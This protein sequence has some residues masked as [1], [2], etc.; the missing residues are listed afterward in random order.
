MV[1]PS[2]RAIDADEAVRCIA[3]GNRVFVHGVAATPQVL[4]RAMTA[5]ASE[6]RD[7]EIV[8]LHTEGPAPYAA[9]EHAAS[10]RVNALFVGANV[11][12]AI[13]QGRGDYVPVF[14]SEVPALFR[15]SVLPVDVALLHVSPPDR[16]GYCSLGV[17]VDVAVS[18]VQT[19]RHLI[20]QVNPRMPRSHGDGL[21]P[22][23]RFHA[24][25][26]VDEALPEMPRAELTEIERK[27][28]HNV[29]SDGHW[30]HSRRCARLARVPQRP[31]RAYRDVL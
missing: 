25:V 4:V 11:R 18:V 1:S 15:K 5:R 24:L 27:I 26:E 28:G 20:A 22:V 23:S 7:V 31:R 16:H 17:S 6:L 13:A 12:E 10:F 21:V 29:A 19:A 2:F 30:R 8:H 3:S 9:L 14:L